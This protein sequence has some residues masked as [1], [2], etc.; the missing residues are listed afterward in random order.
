MTMP[1]K[2]GVPG[3]EV[4]PKEDVIK[5]NL[6]LI[7]LH[8]TA[9]VCFLLGLALGAVFWPPDWWDWAQKHGER[10]LRGY[11]LNSVDQCVKHYKKSGVYDYCRPLVN[12]QMCENVTSIHIIDDE[13]ISGE[14]FDNAY[15]FTGQPLIVRNVTHSWRAMDEFDFAFFMDIY[16]RLN[17][18]VLYNQEGD[19]QF[20]AWEFSEF[21]SM[22]QVFGMPRSRYQMK[23]LYDPWYIGWADC[24]PKAREILRHYYSTPWFLPE[25]SQSGRRDWF[26]MGT[27]GYGA[28]FHIDNVVHPS[29]QAQIRGRKLWQVRP[30]PECA[31]KCPSETLEATLEPG[32]VIVV[33]TNW[34]YHSTSVLDGLSITITNEYT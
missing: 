32:D 7:R 34:W 29:W 20:F 1:L 25:D 6:V 5:P 26:F 4:P 16:D 24:D 28:P 31:W 3:T 2:N 30:P 14:L 19:C 11:E 9:R 12:C 22:D 23:G 15:A 27:P 10:T 13:D 21:S 8:L 18:P 33:N 17:S